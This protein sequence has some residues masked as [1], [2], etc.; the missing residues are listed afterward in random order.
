MKRPKPTLFYLFA[1]LLLTGLLTNC[2]KVEDGLSSI[3]WQI[4]FD[5]VTTT[6]D[7]QFIDASTGLP[8]GANS[9]EEIPVTLSGTD[10]QHILD[11]AGI[12]Q[13]TFYSTKGALA[14]AL[15]PDRPAPLPQSPVRFFLHAEHPGYIP[16]VVPV[17]SHQAGINPMKVYLISTTSAVSGTEKPASTV[18]IR[19]TAGALTDSVAVATT[20]GQAVLSMKNGTEI[21]AAGGAQLSGDAR[22]TLLYSEGGT[23]NGLKTFPGG[24]LAVSTGGTPGLISLAAGVYLGIQDADGREAASLSVPVSAAARISGAVYDPYTKTHLTAGQSVPLW[25]LNTTTGSWESRGTAI[26][27][28]YQSNLVA[29]F[30][31]ATP[32]QYLLGWIRE[33][34]CPSPLILH[35]STLPEYNEIPYAFVLNVFEVFGEEFRFVRSAA[36]CGRVDENSELRF[37]PDNSELVFRFEPYVSEEK[38]YYKNPDPILLTGF[39][40]S[41]SPVDFDLLPKPNSTLKKIEVVF[42][43]VQHNNTRYNPKLFPG[44]Y[45]KTGTTLWQSALVY[46]G[47]AYIVNPVAGAQYEMGINFKGEFHL[48]EVTVGPEEVVLVEIAID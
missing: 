26:L 15:H 19:L 36:I 35:P 32:G 21:L 43:D 17:L 38:P 30:S 3:T 25:F 46:E 48:K 14:L 2:K 24:Q 31:M 23:T 37:L 6:W 13:T 45:R 39:C 47:Q 16:V 5:L 33:N 34:L 20:S 29:R 10:K 27:E 28:A 44:Y 1:I 7:I 4:N 9:E 42:I 18:S 40:E 11:L 8:I 22:V 41:G 12:R